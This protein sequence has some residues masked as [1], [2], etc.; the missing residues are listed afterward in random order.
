MAVMPFPY[1]TIKWTLSEIGLMLANRTINYINMYAEQCSL[2]GC[3][4][5][6]H[7]INLQNINDNTKPLSAIPC[8][9]IMACYWHRVSLRPQ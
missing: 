8:N 4:Y 9:D 5:N 2:L 1:G 3:K 7:F 6:W